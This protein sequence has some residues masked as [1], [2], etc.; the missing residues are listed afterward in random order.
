MGK[1]FGI[2]LCSTNNSI[3]SIVTLAKDELVHQL[4]KDQVKQFIFVYDPENQVISNIGGNYG[5]HYNVTLTSKLPRSAP[6][7]Y[8]HW[9]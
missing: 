8:W 5:K 1:L 2:T 9:Y 3:Q 4:L 6:I 7:C